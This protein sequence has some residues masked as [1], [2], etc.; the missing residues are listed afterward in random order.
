MK[1]RFTNVTVKDVSDQIVGMPMTVYMGISADYEATD[2]DGFGNVAI[3]S[4]GLAPSDSYQPMYTG[5]MA[6]VEA[7]TQQ[8]IYSDF[9]PAEMIEVVVGY[10]FDDNTNEITPV[11]EEE[12][13]EEAW[14]AELQESL[15][16][17][18]DVV[19][20]TVSPKM[21]STNNITDQTPINL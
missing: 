6:Q 21:E 15:D 19:Q 9:R 11:I 8:Q 16:Y 12:S 17:A 5:G 3:D 10:E 4:G 13:A 2:S 7:L 20:E 14:L 18:I 1:L